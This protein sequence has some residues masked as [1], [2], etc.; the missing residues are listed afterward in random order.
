MKWE[1]ALKDYTLY[2]KI[3]RGLSA[4]S[5]ASYSLDVEKLIKFLDANNMPA[6]PLSI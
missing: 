6:S 4:N 5:I 3:E 1:H 2:L